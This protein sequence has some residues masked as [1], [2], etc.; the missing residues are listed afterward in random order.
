MHIRPAVVVIGVLLAMWLVATGV[1]AAPAAQTVLGWQVIGSGGGYGSS[2]H[3]VLDGSIGQPVVGAGGSASYRLGA[4][5]GY[6][7][8]EAVPM[9][10]GYR[11]YLPVSLKGYRKP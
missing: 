10:P 4:G 11:M 1:L 7:V 8:T 6:G 2:T 3:Y 5:Y 9:P